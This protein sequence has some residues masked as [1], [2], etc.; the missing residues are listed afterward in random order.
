[1]LIKEYFDLSTRGMIERVNLLDGSIYRKL[2]ETFF[3][4]D[5]I[6]EKADIVE[7]LKK[8]ASI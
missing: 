8:A 6:W 1:M 5:Y 4:D 2:S 7:A 3:L